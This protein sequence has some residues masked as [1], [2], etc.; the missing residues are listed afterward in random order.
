MP[1]LCRGVL[2]YSEFGGEKTFVMIWISWCGSGILSQHTLLYAFLLLLNVLVIIQS[3]LCSFA[4][5]TC[6]KPQALN[7]ETV[8]MWSI[9]DM[10][11]SMGLQPACYKR[12]LSNLK[13]Y[14]IDDKVINWIRDFLS[15]RKQQDNS[16]TSSWKQVSA[17]V[18][19]GSV[20]GPLLF[21]E[22]ICQ[23]KDNLMH[24]P[25]WICERSL[26]SL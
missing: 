10:N 12:Q 20:S 1:F 18:P 7:P 25:S 8:E 24:I 19:Q 2:L 6:K 16:A 21:I 9:T 11:M 14:C 3:E 15:K 13:S 22:M 23:V 5:P 26:V 17:G 4:T